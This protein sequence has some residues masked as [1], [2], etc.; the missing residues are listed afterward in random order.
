MIGIFDQEG[1]LGPFSGRD[2]YE[3][4][5]SLNRGILDC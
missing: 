5:F 4:P 2:Q 3:K 1:V